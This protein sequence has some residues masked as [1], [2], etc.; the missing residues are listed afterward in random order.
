MK[1]L[2]YIAGVFIFLVITGPLAAQKRNLVAKAEKVYSIGEYYK[3]IEKFKKAYSKEK[4][5]VKKTEI[6]FK[7]AQCYRLTNDT[8]RAASYYSRVI[9]RK[10]PEPKV[11]YYYAE[12]LKINGKFKEAKAAYEEYLKNEPADSVALRAYQMVDSIQIWMKYPTRYQITEIKDIN[13]RDDDF[14]PAYASDDY[15]ELYFTSSREGAT[16]NK[17]HGATGQSFTDIFSTRLDNKQKWSEPVPLEK[18]INTLYDDGAPWISPDRNTL[19]FTRCRYDK[20]EELGCQILV[21]KKSSGKWAEPTILPI[22]K[23]SVVVAHPSLTDDELTL[24]FVSDMLG[25]YGGKDLWKVTRESTSA[26]WGEPENMGP[27]I[28]TPRDEMFPFVRSDTLLYFSSN[29]HPGMGGL[30]IFKAHQEEG[31]EWVIENM[32]CPINSTGDDFGILFQP[33][34]E[35]GYFS[36]NRKNL[37]RGGDDIFAFMLPEKR[38]A[39]KGVVINEKTGLPLDKAEVRLIG[40]DGTSLAYTTDSTGIF[41]F[42]LKEETDYIAVS[43]KPG[44]LN[45]KIRETTMGMEDSKDFD[46]KLVLTPIEKPIELPN[47]LYDLAKWSLRPESMVALDGLVE[48]LEDNPNITIE[49]MSHTDIRPFK[50]MSNLELSQKRAQSVVDYLIGKGIA[51]DRLKARGYGP[52]VPRVVDEKIAA[53]Y[54]FLHP[55]DTLNKAFIESLKDKDL[56]EI[57]HQLNRRTQFKVLSTDYVPKEMREKPF[58]V[59]QQL[60]NKGMEELNKD[61]KTRK[62]MEAKRKKAAEIIKKAGGGK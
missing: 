7:I 13:T 32:K 44:F 19:Y 3:A 6:T 46:V 58:D 55:G 30:D 43:F 25:G 9:R 50:T 11:Y 40:S 18:T 20:N 38:F 42:R 60:I 52:D 56:Q 23:D 29:G 51:A 54:D 45:G 26:A 2:Q 22:A 31:G 48:T 49:L 33:N 39:M 12:M 16:G 35:R 1:W 21:S 24:V 62:I 15:R 57:A 37:T 27:E 8:R 61:A 10:Y 14:S 36:S 53:Q 41:S 5:K 59:Q 28:N 47:I 17:M 34:Q 4:D